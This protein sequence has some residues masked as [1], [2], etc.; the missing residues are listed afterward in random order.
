MNEYH[1]LYCNV[2]NHCQEEEDDV[3]SESLDVL[4]VIDG[5]QSAVV[6]HHYYSTK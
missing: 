1:V 6:Q 3:P 5:R 4:Q 2:H